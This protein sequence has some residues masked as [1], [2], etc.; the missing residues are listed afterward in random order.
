MTLAVLAIEAGASSTVDLSR[1]DP[2]D[3]HAQT[4]VSAPQLSSHDPLIVRPSGATGGVSELWR[5]SGPLTGPAPNRSSEMIAR[6]FLVAQ[7]SLF[8]LKANDVE[9]MSVLGDSP[10][11]PSG[12]RMLRVEQR[13]RGV[14][15]FGSETRLLIDRD[16]RLWRVLGNL[17]PSVTMKPTAR[18]TVECLPAEDALAQWLDR[19]GLLPKDVAMR[20]AIHR[21]NATV[22][23]VAFVLFSAYIAHTGSAEEFQICRSLKNDR[24]ARRS[25]R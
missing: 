16:G 23:G 3:R 15:V 21:L 8:G 14:P 11:G 10:G 18:K 20:G 1:S 19:R 13:I 17:V 5:R 25:R 12:L 2:G 7:S 4:E 6:D 9:T 22:G 24:C